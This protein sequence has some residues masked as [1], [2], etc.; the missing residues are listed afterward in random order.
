MRCLSSRL[1]HSQRLEVV[2]LHFFRRWL[3]PKRAVYG[4][5]QALIFDSVAGTDITGK[6]AD[7]LMKSVPRTTKSEP[8]LLAP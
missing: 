7:G 4:V 3:R 2:L 5:S 6:P 8:L 1:G